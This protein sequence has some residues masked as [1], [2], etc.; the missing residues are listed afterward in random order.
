MASNHVGTN[1]EATH[2]HASIKVAVAGERAQ[3]SFYVVSSVVIE[4]RC[5]C[6]CALVCEK[7]FDL[8]QLMI[9]FI[10]RITLFICTNGW[11][12][13]KTA[14]SGM[15]LVNLFVPSIGEEAQ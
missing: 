14:S 3:S 10:L 11:V 15:F 8:C 2:L 6:V 7:V 13:A 1:C 5:S 4:L 12:P 9:I